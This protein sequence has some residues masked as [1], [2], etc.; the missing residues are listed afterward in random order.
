MYRLRIS[1][2]A[3]VAVVPSLASGPACAGEHLVLRGDVTATRD[4]ITLGDLVLDPPAEIA[5]SPLFRSP[6]LGQAGTI[7][8]R[9]IREAVE[10][11]GREIETGGRIQITITRAARRIGPAE[12]EAAL[13][14]TLTKEAGLDGRTTGI[15]FDGPAPSMAIDPSAGGD[16]VASELSYDARSRRVVATVWVGPSAAERRATI[17]VSGTAVDLVE[18]AVLTRGLE[19]GETVRAADLSLERRPRDTVAAEA[20]LD[21]SP[22][23]G[24]VARHSL[25]AGSI[26]RAGDLARPDVVSRGETVTVSYEAPGITLSLRGKASDKG[27][28]GD[29]IGV[30]GPGSKKPLQAI[31]TGPGRVS[32]NTGSSLSAP[33][34]RVV[35]SATDQP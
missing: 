15:N 35:A 2:L 26:V 17:R 13:R 11:L 4:V 20:I 24:R 28:I 30:V 8:T 14:R 25:G 10:A 21:G 3:A 5:A 29:T 27:A 23:P 34:Q 18:V 22:L 33:P 1:L 7:Q 19:R 16:P 6:A 32:V 9:R 31:V 12:I